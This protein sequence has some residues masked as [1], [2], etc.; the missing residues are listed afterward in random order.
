MILV[1]SV[2]V[3]DPLYELVL[4]LNTYH[5]KK[6]GSPKLIFLLKNI[7]TNFRKLFYSTCLLNKFQS[8]TDLLIKYDQ[9]RAVSTQIIEY[10]YYKISTIWDISYEISKEL[11]PSEGK[12]K[13]RYDFLEGKFLKYAGGSPSLSLGWYKK[14]NNIR[15][16]IVHGGINVMPFHDLDDSGASRIFFQ[17]YNLDLI[18]L[19]PQSP[20]YTF[21]L[22]NCINFADNY[23]ALYTHLL[24]SYLLDFFKVVL[25]ELCEKHD[26]D[27][28]SLSEPEE[29]T[30]FE[31]QV[32]QMKSWSLADAAVFKSVTDNM[33]YLS[34]NDGRVKE[35][36]RVSFGTV[37]TY[38]DVFPFTLMKHIVEPYGYSS[39]K[40]PVR[41]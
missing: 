32:A 6:L 38:Y 23:F 39:Q 3:P 24:Y 4:Y 36:S 25:A 37:S 2:R 10:C 41:K 13:D 12:V 34:I 8:D 27:I 29:L 31:S 21:P 14:I 35:S 9:T 5:E 7:E 11:T 15:N 26:H 30:F 18:D 17:A 19:T 28:S 1:D 22:R 20:Y 40:P 16:R 33:I